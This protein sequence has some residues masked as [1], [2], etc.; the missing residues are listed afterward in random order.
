MFVELVNCDCDRRSVEV[1][2][3]VRATVGRNNAPTQ[4]GRNGLG[5]AGEECVAQRSRAG[6]SRDD[7]ERWMRIIQSA[8][9]E[10]PTEQLQMIVNRKG[11]SFMI[12]VFHGCGR[13]VAGY[14]PQAIVLH[15]LHFPD[16]GWL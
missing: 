4:E 3:D 14:N 1:F 5:V 7:V 12:K 10:L 13:V 2:N 15:S 6:G 9:K 16:V 8:R 11:H